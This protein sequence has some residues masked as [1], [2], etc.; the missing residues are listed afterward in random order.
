MART[1]ISLCV[2]P[3]SETK[4]LLLSTSP[5][6]TYPWKYSATR[7]KPSFSQVG[8]LAIG[9]TMA[10]SLFDTLMREKDGLR[11]AVASLNTVRRKGKKTIH[12]VDVPED[13]GVAE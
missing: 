12:L 7:R 5:Y 13:D 8:I 2:F 10:E 1:T 6:F 4:S 9:L 11:K 3:N